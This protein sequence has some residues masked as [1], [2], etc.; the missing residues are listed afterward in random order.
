MGNLLKG[1]LPVLGFIIIWALSGIYFVDTSEEAVIFRFEEHVA[2]VTEAGPKWRVPWITDVEKVNVS[3]VRRIE[4][5]FRT[6][7]EGNSEQNAQY[8]DVLSE[9][10]M[11]T[12]D[13]NLVDIELIVQWIVTDSEEYILKVDNPIDTLNVSTESA[14]RRVVASHPLDDALTDN[15]R[16]IQQEVKD[17]LQSIVNEYKLGITIQDVQLQDVDPPSEV[18]Q[19]FKDVQNAKEEKEGIINQ[20]ESFANDVLP[21]AR[22]NAAEAVNQAEAYKE[23]RISE[24]KGDVAKFNEILKKYKLG[25]Q[26]TRTRMYLETMEEVLPN[27]EVYIVNDKGETVKFLPLKQLTGQQ[28]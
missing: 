19:A 12:K 24:A 25:P 10:I 20:A 9:S 2:T 8:Q 3:E 6:V 22:G 27:A 13:E 23:Q 1:W 15:K 16:A 21:K 26:V 17:D 11:F 4:K 28:Q 5:G 14:L 18:Q 7:S